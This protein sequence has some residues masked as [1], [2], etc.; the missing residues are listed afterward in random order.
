LNRT[1]I[2]VAPLPFAFASMVPVALA[3]TLVAPP[4]DGA[5]AGKAPRKT[6]TSK[7]IKN[8][9]VKTRDIAKGAV[10][11]PQLRNESVTGF[12]VADGSLGGNEVADGSLSSAD[13]ADR[14]LG[15]RDVGLDA[16]GGDEINEASLNLNVLQARLHGGCPAG[17]AVQSVNQTGDPQCI[18]VVGSLAGPI[19]GD[20]T[21]MLPNPTIAQDAINSLKVLNDS[22]TGNDVAE[23]TL[24]IVPNSDQLDGIN[25]TEFLLDSEA[26]GFLTGTDAATGDLL[27]STFGNLQ[28]APNA[29]GGGDINESTLGIVPDAD[30]L[31][32]LNSGAFVLDSEATGFLEGGDSATGDLAGSTFN[33][34]QVGPNAL[35][36]GDID[37]TTLS[38]GSISGVNA[39]QLGGVSLSAIDARLDALCAQADAV[40]EEVRDLRA[41][42]DIPALTGVGIGLDLSAVN[43]PDFDPAPCQ[44]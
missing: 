17:Q 41:A 18:S 7:S 19:G 9:Q 12:K 6:V 36:G 44:G 13:V 26:A 24:G 39:A 20:L 40:N 21:G 14:Q 42:L 2:S 28:V 22:L 25:S 34:L 38:G 16:L 31:D 33:N 30:Q 11:A 15:G 3:L 32:G 29:I 4:A 5:R 27:G 10:G 23:S 1:C 37:E 35:G 43:L 8:R